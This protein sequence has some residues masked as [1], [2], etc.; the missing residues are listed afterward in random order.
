MGLRYF[1]L[2]RALR[3]GASHRRAARFRAVCCAAVVIVPCALGCS[4]PAISDVRVTETSDPVAL[5]SQRSPILDGTAAPEMTSIVGIVNFAGGLCSGSLIAP[6]LVLTA[7]HCIAASE[8][9]TTAVSC[10][11]TTLDSPDSA[12]AVFV[13]PLPQVSD[14]PADY[15]AVSAIRT[16]E[17]ATSLCG[18]DV[19]LL[20]LTTALTLPALTPRTDAP[21]LAG[22]AYTAVGYGIDGTRAR[23]EAGTRR[24]LDGLSVECVGEECAEDSVFPN[25]WRGPKGACSG[26]SGGPALDA[27]GR[28]IGV[29]SRGKVGCL[30]N[31]YADVFDYGEWLREAGLTAAQA[32]RYRAPQ[33]A[34]PDCAPEESESLSSSCS[35]GLASSHPAGAWL[36]AFASLFALVS[37]RRRLRS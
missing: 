33:W 17:G 16:P 32:G 36:A 22:E 20:Q 24:E 10:D 21:L 7:R 34:C 2:G 28:V 18:S 5:G 4:S 29:L 35:F 15:H 23:G 3:R 14:N 27:E 31:V 12:G 25:E 19:A 30:S 13:V 9:D 11:E 1:Q 26:D 6:N 8:D 37:R